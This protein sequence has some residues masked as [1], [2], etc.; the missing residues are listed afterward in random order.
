LHTLL[1][2]A[3][4]ISLLAHEKLSSSIWRSGSAQAIGGGLEG[5]CVKNVLARARCC[6]RDEGGSFGAGLQEQASNSRKLLRPKAAVVN[7]TVKRRDIDHVMCGSE[8]QVQ[9]NRCRGIETDLLMTSKP[10]DL[11]LSGMS[12]A[13]TCLL[14]MW[15][16][17]YRW[18]DSDL[19]SGMELETLTGDGKGKG[20]SGRTVRPKVPMRRFRFGL[21]HSSDEAGQCPWS[22]GGGPSA[23]RPVRSTGDR[24]NRAVATEGGSLRWV[25]RAV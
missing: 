24:R 9:T 12:M 8:R 18:C 17:V 1:L 15:C 23:L 5:S 6:T 14:A 7:V 16:P 19:G 21:P 25:V 10:G 22:E 11:P 20:T 13:G 2:P 4:R 3:R